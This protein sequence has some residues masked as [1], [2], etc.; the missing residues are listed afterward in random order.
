[1]S[2]Y[3]S[4]T[5]SM[6]PSTRQLFFRPQSSD[7]DVI[8][9]ILGQQQYDL[10]QIG[11]TPELMQYVRQR[12]AEGL[13]PLVVDAGANIGVSAIYFLANLPEARVVAVE[14]NADNFALLKRNVQGLDV[15]AIHGAMSSRN[16][17]AR[18]LDP[19]EGHWAY[20]TQMAAEDDA[21]AVPCMTLD[22][23]FEAHASGFFPFI[24]KV[25]IEGAEEDLFSAN[26]GWVG[27]TPL[28]I[29]ELH[30]W[31]FPRRGT[32]RPFLQCIAG[33]DRDFVYRGE[34]VYSIAN[35]LD[36]LR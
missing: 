13:R 22:K 8:Q 29:V 18:V 9:Q 34:D 17:R 5:V 16:G 35:D 19:G 15:E 10:G 24:V 6:G 7:E 3:S 14:P 21:G 36:G 23:I 2:G 32:S 20:R 28:L 26:T 33:L 27:R 12:A 1:M 30:D 11:R 25:D 31:L 4:T